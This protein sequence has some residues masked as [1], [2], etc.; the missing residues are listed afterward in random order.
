M[1][2]TPPHALIPGDPLALHLHPEHMADL[3]ASGLADETIRAAGVYSL[4]PRY[5]EH[6]FRRGDVPAEVLSAM[7]F[8]YQGGDF[9]RIKLFPSLGKMKYAQPPGTGARLYMPFPVGEGPLYVAEGEKKTLAAKQAGLAAAGV[10]GIWNWLTKSQPIDDLGLI[11]GERDVTIIPDSDVWER[12]DLLRAIYG[13]G[14]ELRG[15]GA[16]V[17]V[18]KIPQNGPAKV[19]LDDFLIAGGNVEELDAYGLDS[20]AF[21]ST[22]WWF[23]KW[24]LS[25][26]MEAA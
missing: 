25:R 23:G 26:A 13:L 8:P 16:V 6:F 2:F 1:N 11:D 21:K 19:G 10:G 17:T 9:A 5:I 15:R 4:A 20:P 18:A 14:R 24:K 3:R 12:H 22:R 7:C